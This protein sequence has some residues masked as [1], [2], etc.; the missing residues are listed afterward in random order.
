MELVTKHKRFHRFAKVM[1]ALLMAGS[2]I[3]SAHFSTFLK[4]GGLKL[5]STA[6]QHRWRSVAAR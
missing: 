6:K 4:N 5:L 1:L 2:A 3:L